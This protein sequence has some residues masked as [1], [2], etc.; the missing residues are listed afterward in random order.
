MGVNS[1]RI[2]WR[3]VS[4]IAP[5]PI[6]I[7]FCLILAAC[8]RSPDITPAAPVDPDQQ[9]LFY[10]G[11][12]LTMDPELPQASAL[13]VTGEKIEAVGSDDEILA[14]EET[15]AVLVDLA[16]STLMPG[17][18]DPH[19]H[20]FN[21]AKRLSRMSLVEIQQ[22]ALEHGITTQGDLYVDKGF[23]RE[24]LGFEE[25][26]GLQIRSSLYLIANDN[27][28]RSQGDWWKEYPSTTEPGEML[29]IGGV[30]IF[31]DGGSCKSVA[32]SYEQIPGEGL[33]DLFYSQEELT[34]LVSEVQAEG[35]QVAIHAAGDR[36]IEQAQNAIATA[37][38]S[39]PN[40]FRHRIEHN[41][42][43]RP[44]LLPHYGEIG[45]VPLIFS[46][47]E[48]CDRESPLPPDEYLSWEWPWRALKEANP[49]LVI[50]WHGD[51][52][53][54]ARV[55]PLGDLYG[56]VTRNDVADDGTICPGYDWLKANT[57][58]I[59]EALPMMTINA[60]Y[61][62]F[63]DDEVGSLEPRK[64]ADLI[65]ISHN[66]MAVPVDMLPEITVWLT[67]VGGRSA[68]CA[69]GHEMLCP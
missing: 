27:C 61:A 40:E 26:G 46:R 37:L 68:Y 25:A 63:R 51:Y 69:P 47:Y 7:L 59:E 33:G 56:L 11:I 62:L 54:S 15:G 14:L 31:A 21:D 34:E 58:S 48:V 52:R 5:L 2:P 57:L 12:V 41:A 23:L 45:I 35:R 28:G 10:N 67:M 17:F 49:G 16:G 50:A 32:L 55:Q 13:A 24:M 42:I 22:V 20:L 6:I 44:E 1:N 53:R 64:Y 29:R 38:N 18:V 66:P 39:R 4:P 43:I 19:N 8:G 36:A 65:I 30:K 3:Q 9:I 60:T